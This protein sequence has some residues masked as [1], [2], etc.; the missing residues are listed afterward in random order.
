MDT[1]PIARGPQVP[2]AKGPRRPLRALDVMRMSP[3][4]VSNATL[5][6]FLARPSLLS[7]LLT[8]RGDLQ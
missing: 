3:H 4:G 6:G 8:M 1:K 5:H 2:A 7:G